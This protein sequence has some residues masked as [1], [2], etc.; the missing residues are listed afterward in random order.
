MLWDSSVI[1][2]YSATLTECQSCEQLETIREQHASA[3]TLTLARRLV[4]DGRMICPFIQPERQRAIPTLH[5][6]VASSYSQLFLPGRD[7]WSVA[8][9][10]PDI[11]LVSALAEFF[12]PTRCFQQSREVTVDVSRVVSV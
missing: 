12:D 9:A 5:H 4:A 8:P 1:S 11:C 6:A 10:T 3:D 7:W 2:D